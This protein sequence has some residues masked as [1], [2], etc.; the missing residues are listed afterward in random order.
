MSFRTTSRS[1]EPG[2]GARDQDAE[3]YDRLGLKESGWTTDDLIVP[4]H[5][6]ISR[7]KRHDIMRSTPGFLRNA[8][9]R[10]R[11]PCL[12]RGRW[13][14]LFLGL[15]LFAQVS[16]ADERADRHWSYIESLDATVADEI[17]VDELRSFV[18][19]FGDDQRCAEALDRL[20]LLLER[21]GQ[22]SE[23]IDVL[24]RVESKFPYAPGRALASVRLAELLK[25]ER[26]LEEAAD[27]YRGVL[28]DL[29]TYEAIDRVQ[30]ALAQTLASLG[31]V[32]EARR[33][34]ARIAGGHARDE[35]VGAAMLG[36]ADAEDGAGNA[37]L[38]VARYDHIIERCPDTRVGLEGLLRAAGLQ[39]DRGAVA[40]A[41]DRYEAVLRA[42]GERDLRARTH[43]ELGEM[44]SETEPEEAFTIFEQAVD[45]TR[46]GS[47]DERAR[48]GLA[49]VA[50]RL[51]RRGAA[52]EAAHEYLKRHPNDP[53]ADAVRLIAARAD[54]RDQRGGARGLL[55]DLSSSLD[56]EV[57]YAALMELADDR[58]RFDD[59]EAALVHRRNAE[60]R[61][62]DSPR[63]VEAI[64]EQADACIALD[65]PHVAAELATI[66]H[67]VAENDSQRARAL[68][69]STRAHVVA[70]ARTDAMAT[71]RRIVEE[72]PLT[73]EAITAREA[74]RVIE[75]QPHLDPHGAAVELAEV[76]RYE[77]VDHAQRSF[78]LALIQRDRLG[79]LDAALELLDRAIRQSGHHEQRARYELEYGRTLRLKA[80][81]EASE[82]DD[83]AAARTYAEA[84]RSLTDATLRA[85]SE[86]SAQHARVLLVAM[87]LAERVRP[88]APWEFDGWTMPVYGSLGATEDV[89]VFDADFDTV[90][91]ALRDAR[92]DADT[93]DERAWIRWRQAEFSREPVAT[94]IEIAREAL[95]ANPSR[96][97]VGPIRVTIGRLLLDGGDAER[98]ARSFLRAIEEDGR[99]DVSL[100][101]RYGLAQARRSQG[102]YREARESFD[103]VATIL[104]DTRRGRYALLL[105]GD[106]AFYDGD[107][108]AAER[109]YRRLVDQFPESVYH[110]DAQYRL[111]VLLARAGR[112]DAAR[113]PFE[114][115]VEAP[116]HSPFRGRSLAALAR[117][118][119]AHGRYDDAI[120]RYEQWT[121]LEP[122]IAARHG[123]WLQIARWQLELH[124]PDQAVLW[125][126]HRLA[127]NEPD[128]ASLS[129]RVRALA[130]QSDLKGAARALRRLEGGF[131]DDE[132]AIVTARLD[133]SVGHR[134][135]NDLET[136]VDLAALAEIETSDPVLRSRAAYEKGLSLARMEYGR[137]AIVAWETAADVAPRS[138]W[139]ANALYRRAE[140][141][142]HR[143]DPA[144]AESVF[145]DFV[146]RFPDDPRVTDALRSQAVAL[147][148]MGR[149]DEALDRLQ[150][151]LESKRAIDGADDVL[152][153][154]A[155]AHLEIGQ[156][157]TAV[158][159]FRRVAPYLSGEDARTVQED[160]GLAL[161]RLG[162][163]EAAA[164]AHLAAA[165]L[166]APGSRQR[167]SSQLAAARAL[168]RAGR[169]GPAHV[170]LRE[171][172][173]QHG[174]GTEVGRE[175][176]G[177]LD[178]LDDSIPARR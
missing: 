61:A 137:E 145:D 81:L 73:P 163:Y 94:R 118:D 106:S 77:I 35:V 88:D 51:D 45:E 55:K 28:H 120:E 126:D 71:A 44:I 108:P 166:A 70:L 174:V 14:G 78:E 58:E 135:Q 178:A 125:L 4:E 29:P 99:G 109:R 121:R 13:A 25:K 95:D 1:P 39:R 75:R 38:A 42:T 134:G 141:A 177:R 41:R 103:Q 43:V 91:V 34:Y 76:A 56:D 153:E 176:A 52:R 84:R 114:S 113:D 97:L 7:G 33:M 59:F 154:I 100:A 32:D 127:H 50:L 149:H 152:V 129:L 23:A 116:R 31:R 159:T 140:W 22:Q 10:R 142:F 168:E 171:L 93:R 169:V 172:V 105:A 37:S 170:L 36:L 62:P 20:A 80:F 151:V 87:D 48:F 16:H 144:T 128:A 21:D 124:D 57:A 167:A 173:A 98:A 82:G 150:T 12:V 83:R 69:L 49:E 112:L 19:D 148:S 155:R 104:P 161:D 175:A 85:G 26:R 18:E 123:A 96:E 92:R 67:D 68:L 90:R 117:L 86:R 2:P 165:Q 136:S 72:H 102:R 60:R 65:R 146:M 138:I 6:A 143:G 63:R 164:Q 131:P 115:I 157:E 79:E 46:D 156:D 101:A 3:R 24:R 9:R 15:V 27:T 130:D 89:D 119:A 147:R 160:M 122:T 110:D 54:L 111:G 158:I 162:R 47:L 133:L 74:V 64:L 132:Q 40:E 11:T 66:A 107:V 17:V 8:T 139:A 30:L 5:H 53:R